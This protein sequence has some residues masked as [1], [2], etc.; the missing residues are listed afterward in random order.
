MAE[1]FLGGIGDFFTGGGVYADPKAI[2]PTYGVPEGDVRQ[3][4]INQ[5][6]QMSAL[7]LAAG[8][9]ME[10]SQRAQLL[11]QIGGTGSQF[12]TNL[13]NAAQRRLMTGQMQEKQRETEELSVLRDLQQKDPEGLAKRLGPN[14]TAEIVKS[15]P[16]GSLRDIVKSVTVAQLSRDPLQQQA[17]ALNIMK[18]QR[19]L[20]TPV[21]QEIGGKLYE[22][23][24]GAK[25][26]NLVA[27]G[28]PPG[29]LEG[30]SQALILRGMRD[31]AFVE[32]PEYSIAYSRLY[33]PKTEIRN[34]EVVQI[35]PSIP[36]GVVQPRVAATAMPSAP[37]AQAP[38]PQQGQVTPPAVVQPPT[39]GETRTITTPGGGSVSVTSTQPRALS[40]AE[41]SL[42][43][44]TEASLQGLRAA[45]S[46]LR[47][48]LTISP[49]AYAGP[50]A[51]QR[52]AAAG[53]TN[54]DP[55]SAVATRQ[56]NNIMTE[57][58]L[59]QLRAIFGGNPTEGER[60][61]L[62]DIQAG[63]NMS[64]PEREALLR[65]AIETVQTRVRDTERRLGEVSRGD[66]GRVQQ[67]P[68]GATPPASIPQL[69]PGFQVVR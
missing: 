32:T 39:G 58:A 46:S 37:P 6:G 59:S 25:K 7:L 20:N 65:R 35:Q 48:A 38:A 26:W 63:A 33:G 29:G 36:S 55:S 53:V 23:D 54:V 1:G 66:Y 43:S 28:N 27:A 67:N 21:R 15:M 9:P 51:S 2:N 31:P 24:E 47:E 5:L 42:K 57:Q 4:A 19:E 62:L 8:Q 50:L 30:E 61:I 13:Y 41:M 11:S 14:Y 64:R 10:G 18:T 68:S 69:P 56:F 40:A 60:K 12:N 3:A 34:G 16:A 44:E 22:Y 45:E 52:G 49:Q 17:N